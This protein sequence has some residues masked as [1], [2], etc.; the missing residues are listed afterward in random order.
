MLFKL[1]IKV[2]LFAHINKNFTN[3][4]VYCASDI[5]VFFASIRTY[6]NETM[7]KF[8]Y[9]L[10]L[11]ICSSILTHILLPIKCNIVKICSRRENE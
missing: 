10:L 6:L 3:D 11:S 9:F 1:K 2:T 8:V 4:T 5:M 7:L